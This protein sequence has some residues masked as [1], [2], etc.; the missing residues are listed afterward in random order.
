MATLEKK[1]AVRENANL[2]PLAPLAPLAKIGISK[3]IA[4][5]YYE[6]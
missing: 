3:N 6:F 4:L 5:I 2:P 1:L